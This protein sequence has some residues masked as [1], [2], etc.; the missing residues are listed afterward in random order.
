MPPPASVCICLLK[1]LIKLETLH[2]NEVLL[3]RKIYCKT[4]FRYP[5][6]HPSSQ[7]HRRFNWSV[8]T[9]LNG[10]SRPC[11]VL[12]R[13]PDDFDRSINPPNQP[14]LHHT[15]GNL[16]GS[17][18]TMYSLLSRKSFYSRRLFTKSLTISFATS[19]ISGHLSPK[20]Q[21]TKLA[22]FNHWRILPYRMICTARPS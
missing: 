19:L 9:L 13:M 1:A 11:P 21:R 17:N 2:Q 5:H 16:L 22:A 7:I 14:K 10:S 20:L 3:Q 12:A 8:W 6:H 15:V 18:L 4:F